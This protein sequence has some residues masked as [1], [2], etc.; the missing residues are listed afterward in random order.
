MKKAN[1][2]SI[3]SVLLLGLS[4]VFLTN[5]SSVNR[6]HLGAGLGGTTTTAV[7]VEAGISNP[8]AVASCAVVGAFAGAELMYNSD[9][10]VHNA[11]FVDHLNTSG[12]GS[13]YTNWYNKK[14]GNSGIIHVTRSYIQGPFK[15]KEYDATIDITSSWPL[16]GIGGVNREVVFGT[17]CQLPDGR[18]IEKR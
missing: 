6:S 8:Y 2:K 10:D 3:Q 12:T 17:A 9:Y 11:V 4:L 14:T 16:I 1:M 18:W 7:C 13:S 5:C 15:C